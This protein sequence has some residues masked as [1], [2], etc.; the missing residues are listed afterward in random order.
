MFVMY[1]AKPSPNKGT[2]LNMKKFILVRNLTYAMFVER[3]FLS[4][5]IF[6]SMLFY[7]REVSP[8]CAVSVEKGS[9]SWATYTN[10]N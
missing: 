9:T 7:I 8:M 10:I 2:C 1:A 6:K 3:A 5:A 4:G